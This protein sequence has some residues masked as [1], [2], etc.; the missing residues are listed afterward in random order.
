[1][2]RFHLNSISV[3]LVTVLFAF[4]AFSHHLIVDDGH[5]RET[6]PGTQVSSAYFT[7][8]NNSSN[9]VA[10]ISVSSDISDKIELHQHSMKNGMMKMAQVS[11]ISV[12][13][14]GHTI[15]QPFGL[16][17]MIF[18]LTTPLKAGEQVTF[19][20]TFHDESQFDITLPI[21]SIKNQAIGQSNQHSH[22]H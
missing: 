16:H 1:M 13:A 20:L 17:V 7:I 4:N 8:E 11:K 12:G 15:L 2:C 3:F 22:Q 19:T 21:V 5:V 9:E 14:N 10:L 18:N 6:I